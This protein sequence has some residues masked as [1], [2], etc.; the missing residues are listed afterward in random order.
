MTSPTQGIDAD[1]AAC[2]AA[3]GELF[4]EI[5]NLRRSVDNVLQASEEVR[6]GFKGAAAK[7]Y[8]DAAAAWQDEAI[9]VNKKLDAFTGTVEESTIKIL[10]MDE[11]AFIPGG[12]YSDGQN[13][14]T[15]GSAYTNL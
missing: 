15:G 10:D 2:K 12:G 1:P 14:Y 4:Q 8:Q 7:Q 9:Q 13:T 5:E 6:R 11:D 3:A